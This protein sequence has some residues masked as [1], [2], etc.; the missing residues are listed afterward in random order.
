MLVFKLSGMQNSF[1]FGTL[2]IVELFL[3]EISPNCGVRGSSISDQRMEKNYVY[4]SQNI[5]KS[6][7]NKRFKSIILTKVI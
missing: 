4:I 3:I 5:S 6:L 2:Y 1:I 7:W